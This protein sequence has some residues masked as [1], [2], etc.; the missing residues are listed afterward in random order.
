MKKHGTHP[1]IQ[2]KAESDKKNNCIG[3]LVKL[4][5]SKGNGILRVS[6]M[7]ISNPAES[8]GFLK[9]QVIQTQGVQSGA[10]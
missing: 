4:F 10:Y 9:D 7:V 1:V 6:Y 3:F 8:T 5:H 2:A